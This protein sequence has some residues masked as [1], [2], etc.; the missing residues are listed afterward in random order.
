MKSQAKPWP[1]MGDVNET[2][3]PERIEARPVVAYRIRHGD[4]EYPFVSTE[5][6][7]TCSGP[8]KRRPWPLCSNEGRE[9]IP[10][11]ET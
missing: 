2:A 6:N 3:E 8:A 4:L 11:W 5:G 10:K 7:S 9:P 1:G